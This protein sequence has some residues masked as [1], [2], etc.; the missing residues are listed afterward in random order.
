MID[1][2]TCFR[3]SWKSN[4]LCADCGLTFGSASRS[5]DVRVCSQRSFAG[6]FLWLHF[7]I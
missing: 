4:L 7:R 1:F 5:L 2:L 6:C 3:G